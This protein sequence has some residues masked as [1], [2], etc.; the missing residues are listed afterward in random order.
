M[1]GNTEFKYDLGIEAQDRMAG[2]KGIIFGRTDYLT[3]CNTYG[4]RPSVDKEG[5]LQEAEWFDES[6]IKS[7]GKGISIDPEEDDGGPQETPQKT[8]RF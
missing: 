2:F 8:N 6:M 7:V 4:L 5:K 3:G 1:M